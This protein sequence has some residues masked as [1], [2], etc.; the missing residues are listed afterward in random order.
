MW[1]LVL[2]RVA[3]FLH[4]S[5]MSVSNLDGILVLC[6]SAVDDLGGVLERANGGSTGTIELCESAECVVGEV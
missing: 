2:T 6:R 5:G 3:F 4:P 1:P